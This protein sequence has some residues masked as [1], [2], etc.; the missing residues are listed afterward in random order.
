MLIWTDWFNICLKL[1]E[2][3]T[4]KAIN[5]QYNVTL[6]IFYIS[7]TIPVGALLK[8]M[9]LKVSI[10]N[11]MIFLNIIGVDIVDKTEDAKIVLYWKICSSSDRSLSNLL[12][13]RYYLYFLS[14]SKHSVFVKHCWY[15]L[16]QSQSCKQI[17][18]SWCSN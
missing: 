2:I 10:R 15:R 1:I 12:I 5:C 6:I 7:S 8:C 16:W 4:G 3:L 11:S 17:Q 14:S 18:I 9:I 13:C